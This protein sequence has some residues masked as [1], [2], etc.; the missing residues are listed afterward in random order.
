MHAYRFI[1]DDDTSDFCHRVSQA[2]SNGWQ[3]H[4]E[5]QYVFNATTGQMRCGQAVVKSVP[6]VTYSRDVKLGDL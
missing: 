6:D 5:P 4:G 1:T 2:L 3:L